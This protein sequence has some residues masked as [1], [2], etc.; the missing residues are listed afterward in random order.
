M[1]RVLAELPSQ[2]R[3]ADVVLESVI[4]VPTDH[5]DWLVPALRRAGIDAWDTGQRT[6]TEERID[7]LA[8]V[9]VRV[10]P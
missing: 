5:L 4:T 1:E 10:R 2:E 9:R 8:D 7:A 6:T 3:Y